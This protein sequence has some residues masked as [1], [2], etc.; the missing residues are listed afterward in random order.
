MVNLE[1]QFQTRLPSSSLRGGWER[2]KLKN[3]AVVPSLAVTELLTEPSAV[4]P[5]IGVYFSDNFRK[6]DRL[7]LKRL[8]GSGATALGSVFELGRQR[9]WL[10]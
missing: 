3:L 2:V 7:L 10:R 6:G 1:L 9:R 8:L 5:D 4:A